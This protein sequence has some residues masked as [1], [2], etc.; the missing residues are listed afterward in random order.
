VPDTASVDRGFRARRATS[1]GLD[2]QQRILTAAV[3]LFARQGYHAT[4]ITDIGEHA[5]VKRGALYYYINSKEELLF[6]VLVQ[7]V[8]AV[9]DR[10]LATAASELPP[11]AK[12][13]RLLHDHVNLLM[14]RK[15]DL[16]IY[17]RDRQALTGDRSAELRELQAQV[18]RVWQDTIDEGVADGA[19]RPIDPVVL[20]GII[21]MAISP[22]RWFDKGGRLTAEQIAD[23]LCEFVLDGVRAGR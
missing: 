2:S 15:D 11:V 18:E 3:E 22:H 5:Q 14:E 19:F 10:A 17:E 9:L 20:K 13:E 16:T 21:G 12:L 23:H 7:H 1:R 4:S 6:S 8:E